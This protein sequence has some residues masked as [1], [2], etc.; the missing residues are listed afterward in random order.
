MGSSYVTSTIRLL[1]CLFKMNQLPISLMEVTEI[2]GLSATIS[3]SVFLGE[4]FGQDAMVPLTGGRCLPR[5]PQHVH[6]R[7]RGQ[8]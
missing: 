7:P 6:H 8:A 1:L 2:D 4:S 5:T 3:S